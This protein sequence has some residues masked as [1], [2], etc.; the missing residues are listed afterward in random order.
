MPYENNVHMAA[1]EKSNRG[2]FKNL[3]WILQETKRKFKVINTNREAIKQIALNY[4][5][6]VITT[7][8]VSATYDI[9]ESINL[10]TQATR[11]YPEI[12]EI[13]I[14]VYL[15]MLDEALIK[16][17]KLDTKISNNRFICA[18]N[19]QKEGAIQF[20]LN[21]TGYNSPHIKVTNI[22]QMA[23]VST[24]QNSTLKLKDLINECKPHINNILHELYSLSDTILTCTHQ[25]QASV[26]TIGSNASEKNV[27]DFGNYYWNV[28]S[29]YYV[30]QFD[31]S[32]ETRYFS[33]L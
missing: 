3:K 11:L 7:I 4:R 25:H 6:E 26:L 13:M 18:F 9:T 8:E 2:K 33:I 30:V 5:L 21:L 22:V 27:V 31:T 19:H 17:Q 20:R 14:D 24:A 28:K 29:V 15:N 1:Y 32:K 12:Q 10:I 23:H 16:N